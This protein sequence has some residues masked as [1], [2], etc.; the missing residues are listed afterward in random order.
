MM[1]IKSAIDAREAL[2]A[3]GIRAMSTPFKFVVIIDGFKSTK[4]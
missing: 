1:V 2:K 3:E 4:R